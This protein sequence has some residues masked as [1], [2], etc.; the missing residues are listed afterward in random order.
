MNKFPRLSGLLLL[1]MGLGFGKYFVWDVWDEANQ[2]ASQVNLSLKM[3]L[4]AVL[5]SELGLLKLVLGERYLAMF[6]KDE[7]K[8][9]NF[10]GWMLLLVLALPAFG[11]YSWL[12]G[13]IG[14]LGYR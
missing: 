4:F 5:F 9:M 2:G 14:A 1:V 11:L 3:C 10:P 7:G 8:K 13:K 12:T 6:T